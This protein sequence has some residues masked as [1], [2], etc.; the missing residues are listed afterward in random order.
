MKVKL[1][2]NTTKEEYEI[3]ELKDNLKSNF[4]Y[5]FNIQ[6][7]ENMLDGEYTYYL[8]DGDKETAR[9]LVQIGDY[10]RKT[11]Q[12]NNEKKGYVTYNG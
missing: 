4:F 10:E 5:S 6:L 8:F 1:I 11:I 12:H 7:P 2:N 9:G 3:N